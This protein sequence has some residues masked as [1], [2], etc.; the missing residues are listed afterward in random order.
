MFNKKMCGGGVRKYLSITKSLRREAT[1]VVSQM[2]GGVN[3]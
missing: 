1:D 2:K 3:L